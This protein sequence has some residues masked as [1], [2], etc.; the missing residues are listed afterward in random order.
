MNQRLQ[1]LKQRAG[2]DFN[3][4]QEGLDLFAQL[5]IEQCVE[6]FHQ[7]RLSETTLEQHFRRA[8]GLE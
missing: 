7:T 4:D 5:I 1:E 8:V 3:P 2:I 6:S